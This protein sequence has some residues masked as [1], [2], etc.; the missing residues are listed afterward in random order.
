[1][2]KTTQKMQKNL[3]ATMIKQRVKQKSIQP[4]KPGINPVKNISLN[5]K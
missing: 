4:L 1:M 3:L 5:L 2:L